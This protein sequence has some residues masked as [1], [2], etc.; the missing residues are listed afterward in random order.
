MLHWVQT[1]SHFRLPLR[2]NF[3]NMYIEQIYTNCLSEA[4]YFIES[5]GKAIVIDPIRD[6]D[7]YLQ[8]AKDRNATIEYIFET[9]FHADFVSGHL[10]LSAQTNAPILY[11]PNAE[12]SF[13]IHKAKDG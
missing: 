6:T 5:E 9:H 11:G 7:K 4:S 1:I 12:T 10:E 8:L 2:F 13:P 3:T